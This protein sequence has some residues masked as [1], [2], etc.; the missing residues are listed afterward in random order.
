MAPEVFFCE[1]NEQ[2]TYDFRVDLWSFGI[3]LIEMAQ[4]D[5]PYHE[6]RPERV[7]AKI[8]QA[9]PPTLNEP[10]KWSDAFS[11]FLAACLKRDP[12]ERLRA[13][14]LL[15]HPFMADAPACH[16]AVLYLLEEFRT[17]PVVELV[18]EEPT[19]K[20]D[21]DDDGDSLF[22]DEEEEEEA[23][24]I[25]KVDPPPPPVISTDLEETNSTK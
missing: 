17:P 2:M 11:S 13:A 20:I 22:T 8:R 23:K 18:E 24:P 6:M 5:P 14:Q 3:T 10:S 1:A 7:G 4:M 9:L 16:S 21:D 12:N 25:V 19:A 15:R